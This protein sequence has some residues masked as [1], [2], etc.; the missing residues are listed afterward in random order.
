M[1]LNLKG[2]K[3]LVTGGAGFLGSHLV[4]LLIKEDVSDV[5]VTGWEEFT[6]YDLVNREDTKRM[7]EEKQPDMVIHLAGAVGGIEAN[8]KS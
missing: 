7:F 8:R 3:I 1:S 5:M 2:K 6:D 4:P